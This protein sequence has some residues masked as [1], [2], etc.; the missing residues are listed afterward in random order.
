ML[1]RITWSVTGLLLAAL[2]FSVTAFLVLGYTEAAPRF[3][4]ERLPQRIGKTELRVEG[5]SGTFA[6]GFRVQR[7]T[8]EHELVSL[9]I[10]G[11]TG[12]IA[13]LPLLWQARPVIAKIS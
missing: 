8:L 1:R 11:A 7:F 9:R 12:R 2:A 10:E 4:L 6:G 5:F 13:M 3:V